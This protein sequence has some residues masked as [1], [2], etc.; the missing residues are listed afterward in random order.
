MRSLRI[1]RVAR[2]QRAK[3]G[4]PRPVDVGGRG[5]PR[6][7]PLLEDHDA[8]VAEERDGEPRHVHERR[9]P[10]DRLRRHARRALEEALRLLGATV[11]SRV[12]ERHD[13]TD[14]PLV[15]HDRRGRV[16]DGKRPSAGTLEGRVVRVHGP[17]VAQRRERRTLFDQPRSLAMAVDELVEELPHASHPADPQHAGRG[18]VQVDDAAPAVDLD[19]RLLDVHG[20]LAGE[21]ELLA[22]PRADPPQRGRGGRGAR[23]EGEH[24]DERRG[25]RVP[26]HAGGGPELDPAGVEQALPH[27]A[28]RGVCSGRPVLVPVKT[29]A[30]ACTLPPHAT[31]GRE[32]SLHPPSQDAMY[33]YEAPVQGATGVP[34]L[35]A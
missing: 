35:R 3:L 26:Q 1:E 6:T 28:R 20:H 16:G 4:R 13:R 8:E 34:P 31:A 33:G 30:A 22:Q 2:E 14:D 18:L 5:E 12:L 7:S 32:P 11:G 25:A 27:D 29:P 15:P 21:L 10:V 23:A 24:G 9:L 19:D 17:A